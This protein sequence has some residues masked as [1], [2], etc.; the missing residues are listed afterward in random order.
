ME[1][2]DSVSGYNTDH[3]SQLHLETLVMLQYKRSLIMVSNVFASKRVGRCFLLDDGSDHSVAR[4]V[5]SDQC[6]RSIRNG[7]VQAA[8]RLDWS[9]C[10]VMVFCNTGST[11]QIKAVEEALYDSRAMRSFV[12]IVEIW[13][14]SR[15]ALD[16]TTVCEFRHRALL[17]AHNLGG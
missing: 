5:Q 16:E 13:V 6:E 1:T 9:G 15:S 11:F 10:C 4:S 12:G 3:H 2:D 7:K 14:A 8:R 17:E